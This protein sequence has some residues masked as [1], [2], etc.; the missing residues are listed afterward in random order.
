MGTA[1]GRVLIWL[2]NVFSTYSTL[3]FV[4]VVLSMRGPGCTV[5]A[6]TNTSG[7]LEIRVENVRA[8]MRDAGVIVLARFAILADLVRGWRSAL[9]PG[10]I[11]RFAH[12]CEY[13]L[14]AQTTKV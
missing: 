12:E 6:S 14:P 10:D 4:F 7:V 13:I 1:S 2:P 9:D 8:R 11:L 5:L 3:G